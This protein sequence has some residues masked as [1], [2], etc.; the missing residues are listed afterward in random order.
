MLQQISGQENIID[1]SMVYPETLPLYI[2]FYF[3]SPR[4]PSKGCPHS[5]PSPTHSRPSFGTHSS[6]SVFG[7][8]E[9]PQSGARG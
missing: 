9:I 7:L 1:T 2:V 6:Q 4:T 5:S 8:L 3:S